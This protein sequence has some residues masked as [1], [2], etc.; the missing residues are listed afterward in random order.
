MKSRKAIQTFAAMEEVAR[1]YLATKKQIDNL[2]AL[3]EDYKRQIRDHLE[4]ATP[5]GAAKLAGREFYL[6]EQVRE[7][8]ALSRARQVLSEKDL[9]PFIKLVTTKSLRTR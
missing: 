2:Y 6:C 3:N 8:F 4:T 5:T 7:I 1:K 9:K